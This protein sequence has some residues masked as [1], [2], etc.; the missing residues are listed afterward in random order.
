MYGSVSRVNLPS[1]TIKTQ[2]LIKPDT[3]TV[4]LTFN[5]IVELRAVHWC[6]QPCARS[7]SMCGINSFYPRSENQSGVYEPLIGLS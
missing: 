2:I 3:A 6:T 5:F 4:F 7:E 1:E